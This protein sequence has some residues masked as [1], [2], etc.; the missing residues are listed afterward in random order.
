MEEETEEE[1]EEPMQEKGTVANPILSPN[2]ENMTN[3]EV[4]ARL[5]RLL[6]VNQLRSEMQRVSIFLF[7]EEN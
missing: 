5:E 2:L 4:I 1:R 3:E 6:D 7:L